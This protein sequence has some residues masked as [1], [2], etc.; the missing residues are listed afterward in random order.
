LVILVINLT[1]AFAVEMEQLGKEA[2][3]YQKESNIDRGFFSKIKFIAK[4]FKQID[5]AGKGQKQAEKKY[6]S[7]G[8]GKTDMRKAYDNMRMTHGASEEKR[9]KLLE[10]HTREVVHEDQKVGL[11]GTNTKPDNNTK[12]NA[13]ESNVT[14]TDETVVT[15]SND[16]SDDSLSD[17]KVDADKIIQMLAQSGITLNGERN[18]KISEGLIGH[19]AQI[20]DEKG[21]VRY[22]YVKAVNTTEVKLITGEIKK[23]Q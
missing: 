18:I 2:E 21:C 15:Q 14:A 23:L 3:S 19:Y 12:N 11:D 13:T 1:P 7:S 16:V 9:L 6:K 10:Y 4:G 20:I 8:S 5:K 22:V 17:C